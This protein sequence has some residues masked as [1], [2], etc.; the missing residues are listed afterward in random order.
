MNSERPTELLTRDAFDAAAP[1]YDR[2]YEHLHGIRRLRSIISQVYLQYFSPGQ[3]LLELNCG[4]GTDA[5]FLAGKGIT[6]LATDVSPKMIAEVRRKTMELKLESAVTGQVVSYLDLDL[7][8]SKVFDGAY[9]NMG[10]INCT[11]DLPV[12]AKHLASLI[13]PRG[14]FVATVMP[15]FCLWETVA[16]LARF[17]FRD[18]FR[19][20][21][22][23]GVTANLHGGKVQTF[24]HSPRKFV[25]AF[26]PYFRRVDI[27]GLN[28]FTPPPNSTNA[29]ASRPGPIKILEKVDDAI[30]RLPL[31][32]TIGDHYLI[33]L[34]R[35]D[36]GSTN[37]L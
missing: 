25:K 28:I 24:Y 37:T 7:I 18:A 1:V 20:Q 22:S 31:F 6:V 35:T 3:S 30:A 34:Q 2:E 16:F 27:M 29:Y 33:V 32:S 15:G 26:A 21:R 13:K 19:R 23:G 17:H 11:D 8:T 4:T 36:S 14:Y 12:V 10:G 9:S 5:L